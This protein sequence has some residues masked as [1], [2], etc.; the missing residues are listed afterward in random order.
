MNLPRPTGRLVVSEQGACLKRCYLA[1]QEQGCRQSPE[2]A[3][4]QRM[5]NTP[6]VTRVTVTRSGPYTL[7]YNIL[8][9]TQSKPGELL[10]Q[11]PDVAQTKWL[12]N[13]CPSL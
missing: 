8:L 3:P 13:P 12:L 2:T 4:C 6:Y 5:A 1:W 10:Q 11:K 9:Y 7:S